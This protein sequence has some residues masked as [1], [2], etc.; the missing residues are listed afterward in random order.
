[1]N[2]KLLLILSIL[3]SLSLFTMSCAK[4]VTAPSQTDPSSALDITKVVSSISTY[5][6]IITDGDVQIDLKNVQYETIG[7]NVVTL[8]YSPPTTSTQPVVFNENSILNKIAESLQSVTDYA[9]GVSSISID[10]WIKYE[11]SSVQTQ[12]VVYTLTAQAIGKY[13]N[14]LYFTFELTTSG[15]ITWQ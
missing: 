2:K 3:M 8:T 5:G 10:N 12:T 7:G 4:S 9:N 14:K 6:G 11:T 1:M 13:G 15:N